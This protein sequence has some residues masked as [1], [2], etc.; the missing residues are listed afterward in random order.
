[1]A[2]YLHEF[3]KLHKQEN[4]IRPLINFKAVPFY[5]LD[6]YLDTLVKGKCNI[7]TDTSIKKH[8]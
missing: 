2:P 5:N 8:L 4:P 7:N 3:T 6:K 1:M